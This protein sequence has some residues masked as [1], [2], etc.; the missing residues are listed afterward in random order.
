MYIAL[1]TEQRNLDSFPSVI[2]L[3]QLKT[4]KPVDLRKDDLNNFC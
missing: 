4:E 2:F 3:E 1:G